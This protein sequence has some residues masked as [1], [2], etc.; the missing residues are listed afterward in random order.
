MSPLS[1]VRPRAALAAVFL[2]LAVSARAAVRLGVIVVVDQMRPEYLDRSDLPD[3]GFRR[4]RRE[5]AVFTHARHLHVPT[6]T[7]PGHAAISTGRSPAVHGIVANDWYD[8]TTGSDTYCMADAAF[9]LG[10][11]HLR[12]PTLADALKASDPKA[13]V[14]A[15][16]GKDRGAIILGGRK[17][18][19][20]LWFDR[21]KGEFT[22]SS[23]YKRPSWL[24]AFNQA[25]KKKGLLPV[26]GARV[27]KELVASPAYDEALDLLV[28]E[29]VARE[30]VGRGAGTDLLAVSYSGTD[31]VGH[32]YGL[33]GPQMAAQLASLDKVLGR[34]LSRVDKAS[35]GS[36]ALAL[37]S[38]HG[39]IPAPEDPSGKALGV[40]RLQW[41]RFGET[42]EKALQSR[43]P[44]P[45]ARWILSNQLPH[46]YLN[47][48]AA[49]RLGLE[50]PEFLRQAA[51]LLSGVD[52]LAGAY[53]PDAKGT[54]FDA[55]FRRSYDP[56]R[57]GDLFL[58]MAENILLGDDP[59]GTS[60][61]TPWDY[62]ARVP[63]VFWGRGV[64]AARV[65]AP[66]ATVDLAP[67]LGRLLGLDYPP[68][69]GASVRSEALA[70]P[71]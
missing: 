18:D 5:G 60:H 34:L 38:D 13:R 51:K 57:S 68:G 3:G 12:G 29:L 16:S 70:V 22:T 11:E 37:S 64:P 24:D 43:W 26:R 65:D 9:G 28:A 41:E 48:P 19:L 46:L 63:L 10:P 36:L 4:L 52:G 31:L 56:G 49:E 44:M 61:G 2:L 1:A 32:T 27:P 8:R 39:A 20:A 50:K 53:V 47:L 23:Y 17:A 7:A 30:R 33:E 67:T 71:R 25:L 59:P 58:I 15:V 42:L 69:E 54:P 62:D 6:E 66:A 40:R 35:G 55:Q 14:F 45:G 21:F